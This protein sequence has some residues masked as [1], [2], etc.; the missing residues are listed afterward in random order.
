[1]QLNDG[2]PKIAII[3]SPI[4][5]Q[6]REKDWL[7]LNEFIKSYAELLSEFKVLTNKEKEPQ[8]KQA[9]PIGVEI[10]LEEVGEGFPGK[11]HLASKLST[12]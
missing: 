8:I 10:E 11:V 7:C 4:C 2:K 9:I 6:A 1:M 5:A 12:A 3:A